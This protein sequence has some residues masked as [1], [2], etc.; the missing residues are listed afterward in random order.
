MLFWFRHIELIRNPSYTFCP[1]TF[2]RTHKLLSDFRM[3][4]ET[5]TKIQGKTKNVIKDI[6]S[7]NCQAVLLQTDMHYFFWA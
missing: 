2:E 7:L 5:H 3:S 6:L 4:I 1:V